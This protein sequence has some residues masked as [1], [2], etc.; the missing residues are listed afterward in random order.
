[1]DTE[2]LWRYGSRDAYIV[3]SSHLFPEAFSL[4]FTAQKRLHK[5]S[6]LQSKLKG[7]I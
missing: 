3:Y 7:L 2:H 4:F 6:H 5:L 1:M